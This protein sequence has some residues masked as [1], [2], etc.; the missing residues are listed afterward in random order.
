MSQVDTEQDR[1]IEDVQPQSQI[2]RAPLIDRLIDP[3]N[4]VF[5]LVFCQK[6]RLDFD[7]RQAS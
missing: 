5:S 7:L 3:S 6:T 1:I 4:V 2:K